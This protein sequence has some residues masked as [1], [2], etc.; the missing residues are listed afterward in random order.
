MQASIDRVLVIEASAHRRVTKKEDSE[1]QIHLQPTGSFNLIWIREQ[2]GMCISRVSCASPRFQNNNK[3][4]LAKLMFN[5]R[6]DI[7]E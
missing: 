3:P 5:H 1:T 7:A 2:P 4:R 6:E